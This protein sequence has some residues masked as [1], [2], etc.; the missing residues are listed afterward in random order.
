MSNLSNV[1]L[2]TNYDKTHLVGLLARLIQYVIGLS[3]VMG[4]RVD[5]VTDR[6]VTVVTICS[7]SHHRL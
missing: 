5:R 2:S 7:P 4:A 1:T 6:F 3:D